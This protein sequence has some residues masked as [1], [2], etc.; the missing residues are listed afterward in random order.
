MEYRRGEKETELRRRWGGEGDSEKKNP[1]E[2]ES[3]WRRGI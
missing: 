2:Q 3:Q 1:G